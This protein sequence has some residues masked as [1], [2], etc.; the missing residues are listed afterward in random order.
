MS[1]SAAISS[2]RSVFYAA[3]VSL[4]NIVTSGLGRATP[5]KVWWTG[6]NADDS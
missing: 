1:I 3:N 6:I 2:S 4:T 5:E